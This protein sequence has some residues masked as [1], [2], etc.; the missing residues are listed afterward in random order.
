MSFLVLA[1]AILPSRLNKLFLSVSTW[2][3]WLVSWVERAVAVSWQVLRRARASRGQIFLA[4][5]E[6]QFG[7][8]IPGGA[9][10]FGLLGLVGN[11]FLA[12]NRR[13]HRLAQLHQV[14]LHV[15]HGLV[16]DFGRILHAAECRIGIGADQ[17]AQAIKKAHG[18]NATNQMKQG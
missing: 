15:G 18:C 1:S 9:L 3:A 7:P 17:T 13:G 12:G 2:P 5:L 8:L 14:R 4:L 10:A 16:E 6:G 11:P